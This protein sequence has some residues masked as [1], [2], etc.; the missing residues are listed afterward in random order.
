MPAP[1]TRTQE[2]GLLVDV[3]RMLLRGVGGALVETL[4]YNQFKELLV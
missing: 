3:D 2:F 4:E 1:A